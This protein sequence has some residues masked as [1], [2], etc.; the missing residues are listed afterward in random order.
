[1]AVLPLK[2]LPVG[3]RFRPTD[4]ELINHYL[5][6]KINGDEDAVSVILEVDVCKQEPWDLPVK[7]LIE[8]NDDEWF[9]FCPKDRKYQNGQRL[10]RATKRGYWKATGKDRTIKSVR[11]TKVIGMKKTL[12]FYSGRA[13][14]GNRTNWV[15][16]EYRATTED[17]DGTKPGQGSFVICKLIRKHDEKVEEKQEENTEASNCDEVEQTVSSPGTVKSITE[18]MQSEP[19]TPVTSI[20]AEKLSPNSESCLAETS[21]TTFIADD[22]GYPPDFELEEMLRQFCD[23]NQQAPD[24]DGKIFSPVHVQNLQMQMELGSS[25][26]LYNSFPNAMGN[27]HKGLPFQDGTNESGSYQNM[28]VEIDETNY[29]N[30]MS[31]FDKET[32]SCSESDADVAQAQVTEVETPVFKSLS[33]R[34]YTT[35][36]ISNEDHSRNSAF[37]QN[38]HLIQP[39]LAVSSA[40]NQSDDLFNSPEEISSINNDVGDADSFGTGTGIRIRVRQR[41]NQP[42]AETSWLQ[43]TAP[44]RIRLQKKIQVGSVLCGSCKEENHEAKPIVAK[45]EGVDVTTFGASE[46]IDETEDISL[47][48]FSHDTKVAQEPSLKMESTNYSPSGGDKE[49]PSA[50]LKA[51]PAL[52]WIYLPYAYAWGT[53]GCMCVCHLCG[54]TYGDALSFEVD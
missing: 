49:V 25:Y 4:E 54:H 19:V 22:A 20:Q 8:T 7:S 5:R 17:L 41:D 40:S 48:K 33:A 47:S 29:L 16:H 28:A 2:S 1:M 53:C 32:G 36:D 37:V 21:D 24:C 31:I 42:S 34:G 12:V 6:S 11:G 45:A 10:N 27:E 23:P 18:D 39:A 14:K 15:I 35:T 50:A 13:P 3:Y 52:S 46:S 9:F 38:K 51:A 26:H 30:I 43:G 44:R